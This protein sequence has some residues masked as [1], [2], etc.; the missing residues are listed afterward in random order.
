VNTL[1]GTA[2]ASWNFNDLMPGIYRVLASWPAESLGS[3]EAPFDVFDG[4]V[5][6]SHVLVDQSNTPQAHFTYGTNAMQVISDSVLVEG[7]TVK[8]TLTNVANDSGHKSVIADAVRVERIGDISRVIDDSDPGFTV[9]GVWS[10]NVDEYAVRKGRRFPTTNAAGHATATWTFTNVVPGLYRVFASW[11]PHSN[12]C[13]PSQ[14]SP[15][16]FDH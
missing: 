4:N 14:G 11:T 5:L 3:K 13:E 15:P 2:I 8:V 9:Q 10:R 16:R 12:R 7:S 6:R 1:A